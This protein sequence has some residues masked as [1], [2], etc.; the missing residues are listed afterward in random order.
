MKLDKL[1]AQKIAKDPKE[2]FCSIEKQREDI[3][4]DIDV[5]MKLRESSVSTAITVGDG[6]GGGGM[7]QSKIENTMIKILELDEIIDGKVKYYNFQVAQAKLVLLSCVAKPEDRT[8]IFLHYI[9]NQTWTV[10]ADKLKCTKRALYKKQEKIFEE[11][12]S[13]LC[14]FTPNCDII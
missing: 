1:T 5:L 9:K 13:N 2:F 7:P 14:T 6:F 8:I 12:K 3:L 4:D 10:I 11:I